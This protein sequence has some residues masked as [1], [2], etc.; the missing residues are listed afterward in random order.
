[1]S[2][3]STILRHSLNVQ[4]FNNNHRLGFR[5]FC[6]YLVQKIPTLI[7]DTPVQPG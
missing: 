2:G 3:Q 7:A 6:C 1:M 4:V 5:Q